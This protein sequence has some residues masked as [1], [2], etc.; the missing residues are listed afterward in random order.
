MSP[1]EKRYRSLCERL[2]E[3][4]EAEANLCEQF[5][6]LHDGDYQLISSLREKCHEWRLQLRRIEVAYPDRVA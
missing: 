1:I 4:L 5:P 3:E 6:A 2:A